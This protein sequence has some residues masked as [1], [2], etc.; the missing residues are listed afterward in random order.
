MDS[1]LQDRWFRS[2]KTSDK[3]PRSEAQVRQPGAIDILVGERDRRQVSTDLRVGALSTTG[4]H[5]L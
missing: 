3:T 4:L 2:L 5:T 1:S